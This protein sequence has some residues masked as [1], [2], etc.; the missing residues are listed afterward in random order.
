MKNKFLIFTLL[1]FVGLFA[2]IYS[3]K[4]TKGK[5]G[6]TVTIRAMSDPDKI[7]PLTAT[8][9]NART[10]N[11]LIF[12]QITGSEVSGDYNL[13]PVLMTENAKITAIESGEWNGGMRLDYEIRPEA[14]WDN[15]SPITA[16]DYI[17]TIKAILNPKTNT[18]HLRS[19]Y[20][21]VGDIVKD[22]TNPKKFSVFSNKKYFKIE[23]FAGYYVIPEYNYDPNKI[24]R[25]FAIRD[26]N[27]DE[28]RS[29]LKSN[30]DIINFATEFNSEKY[31]RDPK[32]V[33]GFGAYRLESWTTG[34]EI[35]LKRKDSWW[36]DKFADRREFWA[37]PKKVKFKIINDQ[38]TAMTA[39]KDGQ[40]DAFE[41]IPAKEYLELEK[42]A[43]F[44][45]KFN[46]ERKDLFSYTFLYM[47]MRNDKFKDISVRKALAH[48]VNRDKINEVVNFK[49]NILTES[50]VHPL[51]KTY[52]KD[53]KPFAYDIAKANALLDGA[54]WKDSDGDG[55]RDKMINGK[56]VPLTVE[57]K[58]NSGNEVRK[59]SGL[60]IQEDFK[61]IGVGMTIVAK[62]W[63]ILLQDLDKLDFEMSYGGYTVPARIS[64][65]KQLW[66]TCNVNPG[67]DNKTGWGNAASDKVIDDL[68]AE[69]DFEKRKAYYMTLQKMIHDDVPVIFLFA[70]KNRL[71][72]SKKFSVETILVN[73]GYSVS[74]FKA[75]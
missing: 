1:S 50:F 74:E 60:I 17:F 33:S 61:K 38:N 67:G 6:G 53:L 52:N 12:S 21:W 22:S 31:A 2:T 56:K 3:C 59:N 35:V 48:A 14:V 47:N 5:A 8:S 51:Q 11:E 62:E 75:N 72:I 18:D 44:K 63:T 65:P 32:Y 73:P 46:I 49:E 16:D 58:Y 34:Q 57:F 10:I 7:N 19:Y 66:H 15:G 13:L 69:L 4:D 23:E 43:A 37:F 71:A 40:I 55:I 30:T 70:T 27:T 24:M 68:N 36:G 29:N 64:D 26:L 41:A 20:F 54:G 9:A 39:L 25:K 42:N 28:K 45:D